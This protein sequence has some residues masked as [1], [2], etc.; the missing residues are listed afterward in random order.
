MKKLAVLAVTAVFFAQNSMI[1]YAAENAT[2]RSVRVSADSVYIDTDRPV[3]YKTFTLA[4]PPKT[5]PDELRFD[6]VAVN[7]VSYEAHKAG[8]PLEMTR[9]EFQLLRLLASRT[10][11]VVAR[12]ELLNEVWGYENYPTTRTVDNHIAGLRA[13]I[14]REPADLSAGGGA[15]A[16]SH[17]PCRRLSPG[18]SGGPAPDSDRLP[19]SPLNG[20]P[21]YI[22]VSIIDTTRIPDPSQL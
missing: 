8:R 4:Q 7:F 2:V 11:E 18:Y 12:D 22:Y 21:G 16:G 19:Y 17:D 3:E 14:E 13:K 20:A 6:D 9:K 15:V 10:G 1:L 5:L